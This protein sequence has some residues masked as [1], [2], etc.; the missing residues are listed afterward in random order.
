MT[1]F[2]PSVESLDARALPSAVFATA[3]EPVEV[4]ATARETTPP[5]KPPTTPPIT[6]TLSDVLIS[7]Y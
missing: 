5:A 2:R 7:S 4:V 3:G 6:I 1:R